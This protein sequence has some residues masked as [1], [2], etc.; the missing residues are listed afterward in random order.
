[1]RVILKAR[2]I[3]LTPSLKLHAK[4]KLGD[5]LMRI[6]DRPAAKIEI[7]LTSLGQF[8]DGEHQECRVQVFM[9]HGKAI[10]I[11]EID[12]DM[13]KAIDLAH[14]RLLTQV[15]RQQS[16]RRLAAR[17]RKEATNM[18]NITARQELMV[19]PEDWEIELEEYNSTS[20]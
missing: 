5:S 6:F 10:C 18:R 13:H 17:G 4:E 14:D 9:P 3:K 1:M 11:T 20:K 7:E 15:K 19:K 8:K 16:K 2:H 12:D